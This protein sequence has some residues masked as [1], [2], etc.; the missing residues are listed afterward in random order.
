[1]RAGW[2]RRRVASTAAVV[3]VPA[4]VAALALVNPGFP[5]AQVDLNDGA[6]WLTS[7]ST[8]QVG[9]YNAQVEELNAGLVA[10]STEFDVLQDA[11]DVLVVEAGTVTVVD[12]AGVTAAAQ[13]AVPAGAQVSMAGGTV[14]VMD[15]DGQAWVRT[16]EDL[17]LLQVTADEPDADVGA[18]GLVTA[19]VTGDAF[20]VSG[21]TGEVTRL[22]P[23]AGGPATAQE[24]PAL[25]GPVDALTAVGDVPVG[26]DGDTVR[27]P[28]GSS[29]LGMAQP[30][31]QQ[32]GPAASTA[33]VSGSTGLVEVAVASGEVAAEH[34]AGGAGAPAAPVRVGTC[35]HAAWPT[36]AQNYLEL[37]EGAEARVLD[38]D[39]VTNADRL[40]FRVNRQVVA[41]N[42][43]VDGRLW[44]PLEDTEVREPD[45]SDVVPEEQPDDQ[46][47][48]AEGDRTTQQLVPEC[49]PTSAAPT[50]VDDAFGVRAGRT[51]LLP[52]IDNDT[53][54]DCGILV[55]SEVDPLPAEFGSLQQVYGGR[56][57]QLAVP[58]GASGTVT[59]AYSI[60]DGRGTTA[61][62]TAQVTLTV[63][64]PGLDEP[65]AQDRTGEIRVEQ[66]A[67]ATYPVLADFSDPDG[68]PLT[69]VGATAEKGSARFRQDGTLTYVADG[70]EL[71]RDVVHVVVSDGVSTA[72]GTVDV[73]VR[74]IGS[75]PLQIDP[76]HAVT[77]VDQDVVLRPLD[78]VRTFGAEQPRLAGVEELQG[79]TIV[80]DLDAGTF[81]F[82]APQAG[83]FYVTF[84]VTAP[85]QQATG[86]AR[87]DVRERPEQA[88]PPVAVQDQA[89]LP[90]G[91]ETT[92]DPL[93]NDS[94]PAGGVL[95]LQSVDAPDGLRVAVRQRSL[96]TISAVGALTEPVTLQYVVSNGTASATG[97]IIV[98][99]VPASATSQPPVVP[100]ATADVRTGGVVTIPVLEGAYDPDGDELT[101]K[102]QLAEPL[103]DGEGLLFVSGENLRYQ[104]PSA[105]MTV[106]ATF[107]VQDATGNETAATVTV[108]VHE[109]DAE[110]KAPPKPR[111]LT[112]RVF[113]GETVRI[114]VPL[115]GI[116]ADGDGITL[117][118]VAS[119]GTKGR[120]TSVG[121]DYL[122]YEAL[123]DEA[124][125]DTF[126]YAVEDWT[127]QRAVATV[128]V[129]I[130]ARPGDSNRVVARDDT[131]TVRPGQTVEVRV[132][133]NDTDVLGG[134]LALREDL[135]ADVGVTA[136]VSG[137]RVVVRGDA[138]GIFNIGY[139]AVNERG[140][141]GGAVLSVTVD[142]D[143]PVL[144]P[145]PRDVVVP[146]V[147]TVGRTSVDVDV[148]A[149]AQNPSGPVGDLEVSVPSSAA[150]VATVRADGTIT[151]TLAE[152]AQTIPYL[153]TNTTAEGVRAYA[154]ISVP[155]LGFF[156]PTARPRA[157]ELR[158][159]S[160]ETLTIPLDEQVQVAPGRTAQVAD[161][162][163][164]TATRSDGSSLV[165]D[166]TT[167]QF[168]PA[169]GYVG[170]ASIT[171]PVTDRT[172]AG[173]TSA[174]TS[175]ITLPITV[176][177]LDDYPPTFVPSTLEVGPGEAP[178]SVDLLAFTQGVEGPTGTETFTFRQV[179]DVP[180]G[181]TASL[182]G[183][184][185][186]VASD[187]G[188]P[189]GTRG[190]LQFE[191]GYGRAG[192]MTVQVDVRTVASTRRIAVVPDR[193]INDAVQ[194]Q[195]RV[196]DVLAGASNPFPD[197]PLRVV[198]VTVETPGAGT[199]SV[200]GSDV[201]VRPAAEL[202][203]QMV[204]RVRVRDATDDS[205][206]EVS[207]GITLRVRGKPVA[208]TAPRVG[209]VRDA[210]VVLS[211]TAPDGRGEPITGYRVVASPG[212]REYA[213][214]STTCTIDGLTNNTEYTFTVAAQNAVGWSDPSP[215]SAQARPDAVPSAPGAPRWTSFGD[216]E[217]TASW[218]VPATTGSPVTSY[219]LMLSP[220]PPGGA[221][222]TTSGTSYTFRGLTNGTAYTL[223]VRAHNRA[224]EPSPWSA[225]S[226]G[227]VP[228]AEPG[229][230]SVSAGRVGSPLGGQINVAWT[231]GATN[232]DAIG[233]YELTITG[234]GISRTLTYGADVTSYPMTDAANGVEYRFEVRA[235]NKAGYGEPGA[236]NAKAY[237]RPTSGS[238]Q[239]SASLS[240]A[241]WG[242]GWARIV[243]GEADGNG[244]TID[245]YEVLRD[246]AVIARTDRWDR[247]FEITGL[248]GGT[249]FNLQVR[250]VHDGGQS[251]AVGNVVTV[252]T[253][254]SDPG[255]PGI[256]RTPEN[257]DERPSSLR[258]SWQPSSSGEA[259]KQVTYRYRVIDFPGQ[260]ARWQTTT[261]TTLDLVVPG[262]ASNGFRFRVEVEAFTDERYPTG[263][264]REQFTV[265]W[266]EQPPAPDPGTGP[267]DPGTGTPSG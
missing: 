165:A 231:P 250:A 180:A 94:D 234:G 193:T 17:P 39:G 25:D 48:Q 267:Q 70:G 175:V 204:V 168:R 263:T 44:L 191:L 226:V 40:V 20:A 197:Q 265:S 16:F 239:V 258:V 146:P 73:D 209:E 157:P 227:E 137:S 190:T 225:A 47:D 219:T 10:S 264:A 30:V 104:A 214:A 171:V 129:G 58:A 217:L 259:G 152:T 101:L 26:L 69:L 210:T 255:T 89:W 106:H 174:R 84:T 183:T 80:P 205:A 261:G 260:D 172:S 63:R 186:S 61:P 161:A 97:Q 233:G 122:E 1:M 45:W 185:L 228:A 173:D 13:V 245:A 27:T 103:G 163:G 156:P 212:G 60:S 105:P 22:I 112:A 256:S 215:A 206:R 54:S 147:D 223:Q 68:D 247:D 144:P 102:T 189:K 235:R 29:A 213:C 51:T 56:A 67:T 120:V 257:P 71:G 187:V 36:T 99:P 177:T 28:G 3:T 201:V 32:P 159:A 138:A 66:N 229:A 21:T 114:P 123:P 7:T 230:P 64:D 35:A 248:T 85:P 107:V 37:C 113:A 78:A 252:A 74:A 199:A 24:A 34:E 221:S 14:A 198:G 111:A 91:G 125:T 81:T 254:P 115:A 195:E 151:V 12:P 41:L 166:S 133:E 15:T 57:L 162:A 136:S 128:R 249:S 53:S 182:Q 154:F 207:A 179:G 158:V 240:D 50:A 167:V 145:V 243:W 109:S 5:L 42:E 139:T 82:R 95:V 178:V 117:L 237:G 176:Y 124:G 194:G 87:I 211:W 76:V 192:K 140:A 131:I 134:E 236:A 49:S 110:T 241:R 18:D 188:T 130:A 59:F 266:T 98:T 196:V 86:V 150:D 200:S 33:L 142:P 181:F 220:A 38:L 90:S 153:L 62:S 52:V 244:Q 31:L 75:L 132:L 169:E 77:Y 202:V 222:V 149:V 11:G 108:R 203:G 216:G 6:V 127:G 141:T 143:A 253:R 100:N 23:V 164:V 246:G 232:G 46:T 155:A 262:D 118:G 121:A 43:T 65:P 92:I 116:D 4:V 19:S 55:I 148:L 9:R 2:N 88:E 160:G 242:N 8:L 119:A 72:E 238:A 184:R 251:D 135:E 79:T 83:T 218:D 208:P 126:T 96:V 224:P 93:A 170:P